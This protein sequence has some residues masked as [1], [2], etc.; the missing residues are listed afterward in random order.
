MPFL[1]F[2]YNSRAEHVMTIAAQRNGHANTA[3]PSRPANV[4]AAS[5]EIFSGD[6]QATAERDENHKCEQ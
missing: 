5:A 4:S 2:E 1:R 6:C 3:A